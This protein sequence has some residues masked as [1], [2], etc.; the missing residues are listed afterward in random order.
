[1]KAARAKELIEI[2]KSGGEEY[3]ETKKNHLLFLNAFLMNILKEYDAAGSSEERKKIFEKYVKINIDV[4][5][6]DQKDILRAGIEN[7]RD[8][9]KKMSLCEQG[10]YL[11]NDLLKYK[12]IFIFEVEK[13]NQYVPLDKILLSKYMMN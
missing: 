6:Q 5:E 8:R 12:R 13:E 2:E 4:I 1:M 10:E 11:Q 3:L 7:E 9:F